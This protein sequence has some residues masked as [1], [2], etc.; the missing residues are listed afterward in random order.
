M[1]HASMPL[2]VQRNDRDTTV[3]ES[4]RCSHVTSL[5]Q[6]YDIEEGLFWPIVVYSALLLH[7]NGE[8]Q[9]HRKTYNSKIL[10]G[11]VWYGTSNG[12]STM[13]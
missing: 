5:Y 13:F 8:P 1:V 7:V 11:F 4:K 9:V 6:Y 10:F 2:Y 12:I 3:S